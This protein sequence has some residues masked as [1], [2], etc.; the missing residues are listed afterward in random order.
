MIIFLVEEYSMRKFLEGILPRLGFTEPTFEVKHHRGK[1]DLIRNLNKIIPTLSKRARQIILVVDQDK[2]DC[3]ELKK[4]VVEKM[5]N[6]ACDYKIRV[7][8]YE[9]EAWFL[10]DMDAI[11]ESSPQFKPK[12][13]QNKEKYRNVDGIEKPSEVIKKIVPRWEKDYPSKPKFA[14]KMAKVVSLESQANRSHSFYIL[15]ETL[16]AVK[17]K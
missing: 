16:K 5:Q 14:E 9:L 1:E 2:E 10:G 3:K 17:E 12:S 6:C 13:F 4:K 8:C 11:A 15:L 7:A